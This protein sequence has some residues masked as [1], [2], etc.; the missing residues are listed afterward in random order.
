MSNEINK[1]NVL[2]NIVAARKKKDCL[3]AMKSI[4]KKEKKAEDVACCKCGNFSLKFKRL[5]TNGNPWAKIECQHT[6]EKGIN[7]DFE[8][9]CGHAEP[10]PPVLKPI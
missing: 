2:E 7:C 9:T 5:G 8:H 10:S 3:E 6:D 4:C 1:T